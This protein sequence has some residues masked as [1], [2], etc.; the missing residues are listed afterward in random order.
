M[1]D[2][3]IIPERAITWEN[4]EIVIGSPVGEVIQTLQTNCERIKSVEF[5]YSDHYDE[6]IDYCISLPQD[7][8]RLFFCPNS[9]RL[10][11]I[12]IID[13]TKC[14]LRYGGIHFNSPQVTPTL[15]QIDSSFGATH[16]GEY[17]Q[18]TQNYILT[19]RGLAF[20]FDSTHEPDPS[21]VVT[22]CI[23]FGGNDFFNCEAP[24]IPLRDIIQASS[25]EINLDDEK[26]QLNFSL[27]T[28]I[29]N[30]GQ[31]EFTRVVKFGDFSQ[32]VLAELGCP[33]RTHYKSE[34]KMKIHLGQN[35][36][37]VTDYFYNYFS[38]GVDL[39]F[40]GKT[41]QVKK[42]V[43]HSNYP[44]HYDF[45]IYNRCEFKI[46]VPNSSVKQDLEYDELVIN[47][48]T[49]WSLVADR[50]A[51]PISRPVNLRRTSS[52][53]NTNPWGSTEC[54]SFGNCIFEVMNKNQIATVIIF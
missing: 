48:R 52:A 32:D 13:L 2:F 17:C 8:I 35:G 43:L 29:G 33:D 41:H 21:S 15:S 26:P 51:E 7:G 31:G 53:N 23:I 24:E 4:W 45:S 6:N 30:D 40:D 14:A 38:L 54:Y 22:K 25:C 5:K 46:T 47:P 36:T 37:H 28:D 27:I 16:P 20:A 39:L 10:R 11:K 18:K 44:G 9:Q 49:E 19:F 50:L 12:E 1:L 3:E 34:D 42:F